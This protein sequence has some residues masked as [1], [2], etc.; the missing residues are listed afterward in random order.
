M[1]KLLVWS[2]VVSAVLTTFLMLTA[3]AGQSVTLAWNANSETNLS[4]YR[5]YYGTSSRGYQT[6][7]TTTNTTFTVTNLVNGTTYYFAVTAFTN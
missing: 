1:K 5:L 3:L 6:N 7:G 2:A 4:G